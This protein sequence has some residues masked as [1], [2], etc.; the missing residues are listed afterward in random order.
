MGCL[1]KSGDKCNG[2]G[3]HKYGMG[4][5]GKIGHKMG[6]GVGGATQ[7]QDTTPDGSKIRGKSLRANQPAQPMGPH[8]K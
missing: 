2:M 6:G 1:T 8:Y 3:D 7:M 4:A 5:Q